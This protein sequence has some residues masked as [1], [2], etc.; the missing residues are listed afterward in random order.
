LGVLLAAATI[1][2]CSTTSFCDSATRLQGETSTSTQG[3]EKMSV[4][5]KNSLIHHANES[6]FEEIVLKSDVPVL[7]D[8][9]ADWCGPCQRLA[10]ILEELA[11]DTPNA[12][13]VKINVDENPRLA[14]QYGISAIPNLKVFKSGN[15]VAE[16]AGLAGKKQLQAMLDR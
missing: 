5:Q 6:N 9:Y 13:V 1:A 10:P 15:I 12:R 8:F 14:S 3:V 16:V 2:V 4:A 7:V 11:A